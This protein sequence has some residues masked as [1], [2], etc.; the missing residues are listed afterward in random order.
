[1]PAPVVDDEAADPVA[2]GVFGSAAEMADA[3]GLADAVH[4]AR[5]VRGGCG[6]VPG[7]SEARASRRRCG[8]HQARALEGGSGCHLHALPGARELRQISEWCAP[9]P[10]RAAA[11]MCEPGAPCRRGRLVS[12]FRPLL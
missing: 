6:H 4:K 5:L 1:M 3:A 12:L 7:Q 2:V 10:V 8:G 11:V 9:W